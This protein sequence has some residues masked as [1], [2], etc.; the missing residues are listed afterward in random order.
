MAR[1]Y[2]GLGSNAGGRREMIDRALEALRRSPGVEVAAVSPLLETDAV[3]GPDGQPAF[4][5]AAAT[6]ETDLDPHTLLDVL[7]RIERDLGRERSV[8]WGPRPIDLDLL[9][10][11]ER[12]VAT[13][14]LRVPHPRLRQRRFVLKPLAAIAPEA[15]DPITGRTVAELLAELSD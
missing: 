11:G 9:L 5:N 8:H 2:I 14:R 12:I 6:L 3:G 7:Q 4:L 15:V 13:W 10:Y 1:A